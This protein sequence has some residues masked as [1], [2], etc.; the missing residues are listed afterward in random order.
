MGERPIAEIPPY[1]RL[2]RWVKVQGAVLAVFVA[3]VVAMIASAIGP[4]RVGPDGSG[5][6]PGWSYRR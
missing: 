1:P 4:A 2:P 6:M 5:H 3:I